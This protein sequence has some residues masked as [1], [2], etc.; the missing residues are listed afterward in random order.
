MRISV[1]GNWKQSKLLFWLEENQGKVLLIIFRKC[2]QG[3]EKSLYVLCWNNYIFG[4]K[5]TDQIEQMVSIHTG[6][7]E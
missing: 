2:L 5:N 7:T 4:S 1:S 6:S 3:E